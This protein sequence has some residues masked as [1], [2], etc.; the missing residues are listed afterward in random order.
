MSP[1]P[2]YGWRKQSK[3]ICDS[4][5]RFEFHRIR[6]IIVRDIEIQLYLQFVL[7]I[8]ILVVSEL[9]LQRDSCFLSLTVFFRHYVNEVYRLRQTHVA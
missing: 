1:T 4:D 3:C 5:R 2:N 8:S 7:I 6:D 9:L